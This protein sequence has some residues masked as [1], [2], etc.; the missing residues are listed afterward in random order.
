MLQERNSLNATM[1]LGVDTESD[2]SVM[3]TS[4]TGAEHSCLTGR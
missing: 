3:M 4:V 1:L 2:N